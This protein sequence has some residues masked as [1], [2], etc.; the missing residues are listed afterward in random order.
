MSPPSSSK[1]PGKQFVLSSPPSFTFAHSRLSRQHASIYLPIYLTIHALRH[2]FISPSSLTLSSTVFA[3]RTFSG[4]THSTTVYPFPDS[5]PLSTL[6]AP[7]PDQSSTP[8]SSCTTFSPGSRSPPP[9]E[10]SSTMSPSGA[11]AYSYYLNWL[12]VIVP[13]SQSSPRSLHF[14]AVLSYR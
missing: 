13:S 7:P 5:L 10:F 9:S 11:V 12:D 8:P 2:M 3:S 14:V 6:L 4:N 1:V